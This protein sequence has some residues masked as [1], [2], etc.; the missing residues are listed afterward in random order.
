MLC[1]A[2]KLKIKIAVIIEVIIDLVITVFNFENQFYYQGYV[3]VPLR[4][5]D[6]RYIQILINGYASVIA[7][8]QAQ[9]VQHY[10]DLYYL[11]MI[12]RF[13]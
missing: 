3:F 7:N 5:G 11:Q 8:C 13:L 9:L 12:C 10:I 6:H 4:Y 2:I 1:A